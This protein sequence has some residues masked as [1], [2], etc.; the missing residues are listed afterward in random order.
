MKAIETSRLILRKP[1]KCDYKGLFS[2]L[3]DSALQTYIPTLY[4]ETI[5]DVKEWIFFSTKYFNWPMDFALVIQEAQSQEIVGL[6]YAYSFD[7]KK[8]SLSYAIKPSKR[9]N[10]YMVEALK[11]FVKFLRKNNSIE[12]ILFSIRNDNFSSISVMKKLCINQTAVS[13][14]YLKYSLSLQDKLPF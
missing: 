8:L 9:R 1:R 12:E 5:D 3:N 2:V 10:G 13:G 7:F 4:C 11:R 14:N 6:L